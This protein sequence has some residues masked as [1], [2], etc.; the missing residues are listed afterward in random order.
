MLSGLSSLKSTVDKSVSALVD[1]SKLSDVV[2]I[3]LLKKIYEM[4]R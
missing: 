3:M 2:K 1:L 4:L